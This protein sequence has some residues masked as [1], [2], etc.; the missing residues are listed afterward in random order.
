MV[1]SEPTFR[2]VDG[3]HITGVWTHVWVRS[4]HSGGAFYVQDLFAYADGA[5]R[6][7]GLLREG[8]LDGLSEAFARGRLAVA[9]P[10]VERDSAT[11]EG[12]WA[13]RYPYALT[14]ERF[15]A[16]A[17]DE[18]ERLNGRPTS[19][20]LCWEA[21]WRFHRDPAPANL[22]LLRAA[23]VAVPAHRRVFV[24]GDMDLQDRPLRILITG[25]GRRID[26]DGPVGDR[27]DVSG[28]S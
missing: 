18:I 7:P 5:V 16:E 12:S 22:E 20:D 1:W 19:S 15:V 26:P 6:G 14:P 25:V 3:E 13:Q 23:Y 2:V 11:V 27:R 9:D 21:L 8:S 24:L 28:C 17:R 10:A 4:Q